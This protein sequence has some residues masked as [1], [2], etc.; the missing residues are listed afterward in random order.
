M[1]AFLTSISAKAW[2]YLSAFLLSV[3]AYFK[4]VSDAKKA[5]AQQA[6]D[7]VRESNDK[8]RNA[9]DAIDNKDTS[10]D[11]ATERLRKRSTRT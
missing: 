1:I 11:D 10:V 8:I 4:V 9:W 5:G 7:A 3:A 6:K 2:I